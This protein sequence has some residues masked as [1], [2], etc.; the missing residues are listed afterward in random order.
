MYVLY[1]ILGTWCWSGKFR[2]LTISSPMLQ[3][4]SVRRRQ[5]LTSPRQVATTPLT[6]GQLL[7]PPGSDGETFLRSRWRSSRNGCMTTAIMPTRRTRRSCSCPGL[8]TSLSSRYGGA[9]LTT[10]IRQLTF[11]IR[12]YYFCFSIIE[13]GVVRHYTPSASS[14]SVVCYN[15][16]VY[17]LN[18]SVNVF[19][20][21][22]YSR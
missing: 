14:C 2:K 16:Y 15:F 8:P 13:S 9:H 1:D 7:Q 6:C 22:V 21:M 10:S 5:A 3:V 12:K 20:D 19:Q 4:A 17:N 11:V 18:T